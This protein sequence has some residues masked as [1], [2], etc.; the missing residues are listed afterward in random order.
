MV[1]CFSPLIFISFTWFQTSTWTTK[2]WLVL[3]TLFLPGRDFA[4]I[5]L[6]EIYVYGSV[7]LS[8]YLSHSDF[9]FYYLFFKVGVC[10]RGL[11][12]FHCLK[13][14]ALFLFLLFLLRALGL[15]AWPLGNGLPEYK[16][17]RWWKVPKQQPFCFWSTAFSER[18]GEQKWIGC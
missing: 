3:P 16:T 15:E 17:W 8:V 10:E 18:G 4:A 14:R 2:P 7:H 11:R 12:E 13:V 6:K 1:K 5:W 9:V